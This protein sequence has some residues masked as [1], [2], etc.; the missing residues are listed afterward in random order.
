MNEYERYVLKALQQ[1]IRDL[2]LRSCK[3]E[4]VAFSLAALDFWMEKEVFGYDGD[5]FY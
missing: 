5:K 4:N 3:G 2:Y 1:K